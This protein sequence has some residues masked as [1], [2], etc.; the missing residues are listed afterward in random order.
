MNLYIKF[1][2]SNKYCIAYTSI[3]F[4]MQ[5]LLKITL[6]YKFNGKKYDQCG[7]LLNVVDA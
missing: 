5:Y 1:L 3:A 6:L 7:H 2:V 4:T